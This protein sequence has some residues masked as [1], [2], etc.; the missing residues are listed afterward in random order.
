MTR[1]SGRGGGGG[2]GR[3]AADVGIMTSYK[4]TWRILVFFI[5]KIQ[6]INLKQKNR[7]TQNHDLSSGMDNEAVLYTSFNGAVDRVQLSACNVYV[8]DLR[9]GGGGGGVESALN[10]STIRTL[11][12]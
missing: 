6:I 1:E 12:L 9:L 5:T 7:Q 3:G 4:Q 10:K 11:N 2:G 8:T